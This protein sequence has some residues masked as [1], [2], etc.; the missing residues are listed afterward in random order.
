MATP[1]YII[2]T[3]CENTAP[4]GNKTTMIGSTL[5]VGDSED[6]A[7]FWALY[8]LEM[9]NPRSGGWGNYCVFAKL[10]STADRKTVALALDPSELP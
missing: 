5:F 8:Q 1:I 6:A 4:N 9:D 2:A 3:S 7:I 10:L